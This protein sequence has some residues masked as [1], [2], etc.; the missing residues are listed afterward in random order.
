MG[1]AI[2]ISTNLV[3]MAGWR[4]T[5]GRVHFSQTYRFPAGGYVVVAADVA[6]FQLKYPG[7]QCYWRWTANWPTAPKLIELTTAL[8]E[9]VNSVHYATEGDWARR[10]HGNGASPVLSITRSG[11]TAT[12]TVLPSRLHRQ[13]RC[14]YFR[15]DQ[16]EYNGRFVVSGVSRAHSHYRDRHARL[17]GTG[18]IVSRWVVD[19]GFSGCR[20]LLSE[21][22]WQL[23]RTG[24]SNIDNNSGQNWLPSVG[25][26]RHSRTRQFR[27]HQQHRAIISEV[28]HFPPVPR[29]TENVAI[30]ARISDELANG[31]QNVTLFFIATTAARPGIQQHDH[32]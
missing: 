32:V 24:K 6:A 18:N 4:F 29:P 27:S 17:S 23:S 10:E 7:K 3:N 21:R 13:R 12:V 11:S 14:H 16:A 30:T 28:T 1:R 8:G 9:T 25:T 5:R 19:D 26:Q 22:L 20:V 2:N 31:I 15:A